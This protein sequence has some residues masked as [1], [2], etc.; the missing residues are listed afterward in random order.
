VYI[1][2]INN[3]PTIVNPQDSYKKPGICNSGTS[4]NPSCHFGQFYSYEF[5]DTRVGIVGVQIDD[6]DLGE[7]CI[8]PQT[9]C[10]KLDVLVSAVHGAVSLNSRT[11]LGFY[12]E[13]RGSTGFTAFVSKSNNAIKTIYYQVEITELL[14]SLSSVP[15]FNTQSGSNQERV[16]VV[17]SDQGVS[18]ASGV[19]ESATANIEVTIVAVNNPPI[20]SLNAPEFQASARPV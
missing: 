18:G 12:L 20:I 5:T 13:L 15:Y 4:L 6:V 2:D 8:Y 7:L 17:V 14:T 10:A 1:R 16:S 11:G 9:E 19:A 3:A